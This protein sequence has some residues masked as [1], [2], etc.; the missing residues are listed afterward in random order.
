MSG[1][2][3]VH[4]VAT[5]ASSEENVGAQ[6]KLRPDRGSRHRFKYLLHCLAHFCHRRIGVSRPKKINDGISNQSQGMSSPFH[7]SDLNPRNLET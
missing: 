4:F 5:T 6:P 2:A 7:G 1:L 3:K